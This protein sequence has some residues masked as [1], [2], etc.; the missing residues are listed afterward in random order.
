MNDELKGASTMKETVQL[1]RAFFGGYKRQDVQEYLDDFY[2][3]VEHKYDEIAQ[4]AIGLEKENQVLKQYFN[5]L[6]EVNAK[7]SYGGDGMALDV[8]ELPEGIYQVDETNC[9]RP[10]DTPSFTLSEEKAWEVQDTEK[11]SDKIVSELDTGAIVKMP[12]EPNQQADSFIT[13]TKNSFVEQKQEPKVMTQSLNKTI[14]E[15]LYENNGHYYTPKLEREVPSP[16]APVYSEGVDPAANLIQ[17]AT[18]VSQELQAMRQEVEQLKQANLRL[19]AKLEFANDL[20]KEL[21]KQD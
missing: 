11:M 13:E 8:T 14:R 16:V 7:E 12:I 5:E 19:T 21:Y 20:I 4:K 3:Q 10:L 18:S 17:V 1:N 2:T 9:V 6:D 15:P